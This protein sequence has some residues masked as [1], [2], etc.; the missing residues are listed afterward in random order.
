MS[1][2]DVFIGSLDQGTTS[3]R[4]IIYDGLA[5]SVGFHQ[6]EFT[7]FYPQAGYVYMHLTSLLM[8]INAS[9]IIKCLLIC[10]RWV[11]H[12]P[13]EILESVRVCISKALDK[14]TADGHNV[15]NGLNAIGISNQRET[16]VI[17]S[18]STGCPLHHAIVWMDVRTSSI[19]RFH[20]FHL[21]V[22]TS[23]T[24]DVVRARI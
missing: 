19:C 13:M 4:F 10:G 2:K 11:E 15:D 16:T 8:L 7:Q 12:D 9:N 22:F 18:K 1:K 14:A 3:T 6:I 5:H 21:F 17:W 23:I 20:F 24:P